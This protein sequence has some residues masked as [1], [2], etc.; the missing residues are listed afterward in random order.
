MCL[1]RLQ[2]GSDI[3]PECHGVTD[4]LRNVE[5]HCVLRAGPGSG[6]YRVEDGDHV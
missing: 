6:H 5:Y 4:E 1:S 3:M 2:I